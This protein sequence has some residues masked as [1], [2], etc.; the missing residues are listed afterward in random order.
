MRRAALILAVLSLCSLGRAA[1]SADH[2]TYQVPSR[3]GTAIAVECA[4]AGPELLIIHGGVGDRTRWTPLFPLLERD[5][6]VCAM[7]R[8]AHGQSGDRAPYALTKEVDDLLAVVASRPGPVAVLG[9]SFGGVIAYEAAFRT[10]RIA[11]LVLYEPPVRAADHA[12]ELAQMETLIR[13]GDRDAAATLFQREIVKVSPDEI[14]AMKARPS[15][16]AQVATIETA[17]RQDRALSANHWDPARAKSLATPTL[18]LI[19]GRTTSPELR[20][21]VQSL[22][23]TLPHSEVLVLDGQEHNAMDADRERFAAVL[24]KFVLRPR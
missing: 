17:I 5:L 3:D 4:G 13:T 7:D 21:S 19:G 12:A 11:K 15:W 16:A 24:K 1:E 14:S 8:R 6:T 22:S 10:R 23:E 9:H 20:N 2:R 18:L